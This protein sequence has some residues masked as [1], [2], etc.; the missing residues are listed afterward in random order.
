MVVDRALAKMPDLQSRIKHSGKTSTVSPPCGVEPD[1]PKP[2]RAPVDGGP[3][4]CT[5][6]TAHFLWSSFVGGRC[7]CREQV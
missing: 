1:E 6:A 3:Y 7:R 4:R 5:F 2:K